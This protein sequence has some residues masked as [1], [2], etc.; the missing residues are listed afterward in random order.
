MS[1]F[2]LEIEKKSLKFKREEKIGRHSHWAALSEKKQNLVDFSF[3]SFH[4]PFSSY[5]HNLEWLLDS[6]V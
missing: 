2:Q 6:L 5:I 1:A 3:L 4:L